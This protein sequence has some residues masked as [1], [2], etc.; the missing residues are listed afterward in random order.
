MLKK[1]TAGIL[2]AFMALSMF[3]NFSVFAEEEYE[4]RN[5]A[6][7]SYGAIAEASSTHPADSNPLSFQPCNTNDGIRNLGLFWND[8]TANDYPDWLQITFGRREIINRLD[9]F[10]VSDDIGASMPDLDT[11]FHNYG[12]TDFELQ[13]LDNGEWKTIPG[14]QVT[15]NN[16]VWKQ[17]YF[18]PIT[19]TAIRLWVTGAVDGSTRI[20]ELEAWTYKESPDGEPEPPKQDETFQD[21]QWIWQSEAGPNNTWM[22]FKKDFSL[23]EIPETAIANIAVDSKYYMWIN[24][25]LAVFEGG[26]NRG[27]AP[28]KG[29]YDSV[30]IVPYLKTGENDISILMW[31]WGNQGRNNVNS[32]AGGMI[33]SADLG[34]TRLKSDTS[35]KMK[36]HPAYGDTTGSQPSYLYGGYN[37]GFNA[38]NDFETD[39]TQPGFDTSSWENA[40]EKGVVGTKP[41]GELE[42]RPIPQWK[43]SELKDYT[44]EIVRDGDQVIMNLPYAAQIT[45]YFKVKAPSGE[46]I[47]IQ[48]DRYQ[49]PGGPG[50]GNKYNCHRTEYTTK[51]GV[52]EF[53]SL[54][55]IFGEQVIYTIPED[56]EIIELKY[57]ESGCDTELVPTIQTDDEFYNS[58]AE[59]AQRTLYVCMR[60]NFMDCPDRERGQWIGDVSSQAPQVFYALDQNG[61]VHLKKA[62]DNFIRN[63]SGDVLIGNV[64]GA[65]L[66]E[67]PSQS[68]NAISTEGMIMQYY[69]FTGDLS[70]IELSYEPVKNYLKLWETNPDGSL[71]NRA[72][73]WEWYDHGSGID[74]AVI[75]PCWYYMACESAIEM[76]KLTGNEQDI[77]WFEERMEG[78]RS[79]FQEKFW[80]GDGYHSDMPNDD[81]ANAMA[82]LSG[83]ADPDYYPIILD[84]LQ[85]V[86]NSTPYME[87]YVLESMFMMGYPNEAMERMKLRYTDLVANENSTLWE[88]FYYLSTK[89]H[90]WSGGPLTMLNKYVAGIYPT[91]P[92][93]ETYRVQPNLTSLNSV[94]VTVPSIKGNIDLNINRDNNQITMG[95]TSPENTVA[96]VAVPRFNMENTLVTINGE[97]AFEDGVGKL[98]SYQGNDENYIYFDLEPGNYQICSS[99]KTEQKEN[100]QVNIQTN[101]G[102]TLLLNGEPIPSNYQNSFPAGTELTFSAEP[103][104]GKQFEGFTGS[105]ATTNLPL[106][107]QLQSDLNLQASFCDKII[108][109]DEIKSELKL[110]LNA[111]KKLEESKY[112]P[113]SWRPFKAA[114][115]QAEIIMDTVPVTEEQ[116][117]QAL[118]SLRNAKEQLQSAKGVNLAL[119]SNVTVSNVVP[120]MSQFSADKLTDG[121]V[122]GAPSTS[123]CWSSNVSK[124]HKEWAQIDLGSALTFD[125]F[126]IYPRIDERGTGWGFPKDFTIK[127]SKDGETWTTVVDETD[128]PFVGDTPQT[129]NFDSVDAR[130]I[131]L[132]TTKLNA[133]VGEAADTYRVQLA[134]FEVYRQKDIAVD[135]DKSIL[136]KVIAYAEEQK[137]SDEFNNVI[138]DV[139]ESFNAALEA[140]K[141]IFADPTATQEKVDQAWMTLLKEIHKLGFVKGDISSLESLVA[142][143]ETYDM[144]DFVEAGQAEFQEVLKAAQDLLA[145][146]EN[147][148]QTE[149]ETAETNLLNAMLNLRYKADKS[150]LEKVIAE[151]NDVDSSAYTAESY[152]ALQAAVAEANEVMENENAT[153][154]EVNAAVESVQ[155]AM[156]GLVSVDKETTDT[157]KAEGTQTGQEN[158]TTKANAA[159]TGDVTPITGVM[160]LA[161]AGT[162]VL[163]SRKKK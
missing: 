68:L 8:N 5:A 64:P 74:G 85:T 110:E 52:Q 111:C 156:K 136:N 146:K 51:E 122:S 76:A 29:Y 66:S 145:D 30:D 70:V 94:K 43:Y 83:L 157:D 46:I 128:Y 92:G 61:A 89:N 139:Q 1:I 90:A 95:L 109:W 148:M 121:I 101:E 103:E 142:L 159:K 119:Y 18:E 59:K 140:A 38:Q 3:A 124:D 16:K 137:V 9:V 63:R 55:W 2:A 15:G 150:I 162:A 152:T 72:G 10:T 138:A 69:Q 161:L 113:E 36:V 97:I 40:I 28:G 82:V 96:Q 58:L 57:R 41:W 71:I 149:I 125:Q 7:S 54:D 26:L 48:T 27:P 117:N 98:D 151:A 105:F 44:N 112:T 78:I 102:G 134:E 86:R 84:V 123:N 81:R 141:E 4:P 17:F 60:D 50:D 34:E 11:V 100:Y 67:L 23:E 65:N 115:E 13:Y 91:T 131:R 31:F 163:F 106:T 147:A 88:D 130:Y 20:S 160:V 107:I 22:C 25:E 49:T 73:N 42:K 56:V 104:E 116:I 37:I 99:I 35:W 32:G 133:I 153:Q 118:E 53:E 129:F 24:G 12:V 114:I 77:P 158:T 80:K 47:S 45:P 154:E 144:N 62:I 155:E 21:A 75:G 93:Y 135:S 108:D 39:W 143:A 87:G 33:F 127:V 126:V 120:G 14:T 6:L 79:T 19:T 132:D